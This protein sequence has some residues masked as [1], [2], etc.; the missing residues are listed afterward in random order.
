[1]EVVA[2]FIFY[3]EKILFLKRH[4]L[5]PE[6]NTWCIPDGKR[7]TDELLIIEEHSDFRWLSVPETKH[8]C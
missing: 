5:K 8:F 2:C 3:N 4:S 7:E 6:G 1:M